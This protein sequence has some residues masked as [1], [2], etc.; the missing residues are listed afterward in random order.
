MMGASG[1]TIEAP[2]FHVSSWRRRAARPF[3]MLDE[4]RPRTRQDRH[5][6]QRPVRQGYPQMSSAGLLP[7]HR[8]KGI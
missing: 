8:R 7:D 1:R 4:R 5:D 3:P 2:K 6:P